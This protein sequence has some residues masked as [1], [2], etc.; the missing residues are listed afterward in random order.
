MP[1]YGQGYEFHLVGPETADTFAVANAFSKVKQSLSIVRRPEIRL[2][3][4]WSLCVI[5]E[6]NGTGLA[7]E[8]TATPHGR[9]F[10]FE[11]FFRRKQQRQTWWSA[12]M[13]MI[14]NL[15]LASE[16]PLWPPNRA[17]VSV[18]VRVSFALTARTAECNIEFT[19]QPIQFTR[20]SKPRWWLLSQ[21]KEGVVV[22]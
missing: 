8:F 15:S 22:A 20:Y 2:P 9:R 5:T 10:R 18:A 21:R 4:F 13:N 1:K 12:F 11:L 7:T 14:C 3:V 6:T 17:S 16:K 19:F